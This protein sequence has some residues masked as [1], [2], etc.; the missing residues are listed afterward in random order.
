[1]VSYK[2]NEK[3][4][5]ACLI[6]IQVAVILRDFIAGTQIYLLWFCD[7]APLLI[8]LGLII[9]NNQFVK[10][11]INLTLLGQLY[12]IFSAILF[13]ATG[14]NLLQ[15]SELF[16]ESLIAIIITLLLHLAAPLAL[17]WE[18]NKKPSRIA[19]FYS[20]IMML[21]FYALTIAF[22]SPGKNINLVYS[23]D[24][25][26]GFTPPGY[27]LYWPIMAFLVV[28]I[29]TYYLQKWLYFLCRKK[30]VKRPA[31]RI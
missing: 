20:A 15:I 26:L 3:I 24:Y 7:F 9:N 23:S 27:T 12:F 1:M 2:L 22:T 14:I 30:P 19:V 13:L 16:D 6:L 10:G 4:I 17:A 5:I 21:V 28:I 31:R 29:P 18:Y 25:I 8:A 11:A